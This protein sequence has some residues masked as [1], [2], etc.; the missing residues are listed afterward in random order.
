MAVRLCERP[1]GPLVV[2]ARP[3]DVLQA[4]DP[5]LMTAD[6]RRHC[7][8]LHH[9][10]DRAARA[11]AHLLM[12]WAAA[13]VTGRAIGTLDLVHRCPDCG[14]TDHGRP[15]FRDL[16][17]VHISLA[18]T[19]GAVVG[20]VGRRPV[21]VD[22][23]AGRSPVDLG[24]AALSFALAGAEIDRVRLAPNPVR[25]FLRHWTLKEC[26]VKL[27]AATLDTASGIDLALAEQAAGGRTVKTFR[28]LHLVDWFD[29]ALDAVVAVASAERPEIASFIPSPVGRARGTVSVGVTAETGLMDACAVRSPS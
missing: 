20:G 11:A 15:S 16:P 6:E 1:A 25:S 8:A 3:E 13:E 28:G 23:E 27:G 29:E 21:G 4:L 5:G 17:A 9:P 19:R 7:G 26:L 12:R 24:D 10:A 14:S 22:I 18:H 2:T